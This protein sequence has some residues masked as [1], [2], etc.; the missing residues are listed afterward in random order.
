V[1]REQRQPR[2]AIPQRRRRAHQIGYVLQA[3][4]AILGLILMSLVIRGIRDYARLLAL[5]RTASRARD[6]LLAT[7]SHDLRNPITA[8]ALSVRAIRRASPDTRMEKH[9]ARIERATERMGR[10]I[11]D[12][13]N[14]A[15]IEAGVLRVDLQRED[16]SGLIDAAVE[17]F[18][19][20][21]DERSVRIAWRPPA[22]TAAVSCDR[23]LILRVL[24]NI[25][26]NAV[27]F[28][29]QGGRSPT[30]GCSTAYARPSAREC[31]R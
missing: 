20:I 25:I 6:D 23:H 19:P 17:M 28:S 11:D 27:K 13:L 29:P 3:M 2:L 22:A 9:A 30:P 15:K 4:T 18:R 24:S 16:A 10:L 7:V 1:V 14:A 26:G 31:G 5:A 12:L 21:A 8:I